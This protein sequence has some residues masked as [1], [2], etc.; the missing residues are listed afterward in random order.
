MQRSIK[1]V[2][3]ALAT[4]CFTMAAGC[5]NAEPVDREEHGLIEFDC[6]NGIRY[7]T[8]EVDF[9]NIYNG[10]AFYAPSLNGY[11]LGY[12]IRYPEG[13][14][15]HPIACGVIRVYRNSQGY[16]TLAVVIEHRLTRP[17][18][19]RNGLNAEVSVDRFISIYGH[20]RPTSLI[21]GAGV[22]TGLHEGDIV[23]PDQII[24]YVEHADERPGH[25][26]EDL[27]GHGDT[28]LHFGIRLQSYADAARI[29]PRSPFR[30]YDVSGD[31]RTYFADPADFMPRLVLA[32]GDIRW[33][34]PGTLL[35]N[36]ENHSERWLVG[37]DEMIHPVDETYLTRERL[38]GREVEVSP[39]EL[40]CYRRGVALPMETW[41]STLIRFD[42]APAV[43]ES[44]LYRLSR[45]RYT[46]I[47]YEAFLSWGWSDAQVE[48]W[49]SS[50]RPAFFA[51]TTDRGFRRMRDG[52]LVKARG[53]PEVSV[54]SD[55]RRL[56]FLNWE[57]FIAMGYDPDDIVE[58][59]PDVIDDVAYPRGAL[60][61]PELAL[62]C[63]TPS[64]SGGDCDGS[65]SEGGGGVDDPDAGMSWSADSGVS[66][67]DSDRDG[68]P[69]R[70][71]CAPSNPSVHA[72]ASELC[73]GL[74]NDCDGIPDNGVP[75]RH[76]ANAC[77]SVIYACLGGYWVP[78]SGRDPS[79]EVCNGGDD[80]CD[81]AVD[82]G[83]C[84]PPP[85]DAGT[86]D[87]GPAAD[88]HLLR[89]RLSDTF[90]AVNPCPDGWEIRLWLDASPEASARGAPLER[91]VSRT[92][93]HSSI[94]L[95]CYTRTPQW[96]DWTG[97]SS[98]GAFAELSLGGVDLRST[99]DI[100][101]DPFAP[102]SGVRPIVMWAPLLRGS[103]P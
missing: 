74:D 67:A 20:Q 8:S 25:E 73:D 38:Y 77:G 69:D 82:E 61:T 43:Y 49:S 33:H 72:G 86:P 89:I 34:P 44:G 32:N 100:C 6:G 45:D 93:G 75:E 29:H 64:C 71:D 1:F 3:L 85:A 68:V 101:L 42:D 84:A 62:L 99:T 63:R 2:L 21:Y 51:R 57:T 17:I 91:T 55:G 97:L 15:I 35:M 81:G 79:P 66:L 83:V 54:V 46:F 18:Q 88:P 36:R 7:P 47:S 95:W 70:D 65:G 23:M 76:E 87:A 98:S 78:T 37:R 60:I 22:G 28:H 13:V 12:D 10:R 39:A 52:T 41:L 31:G 96:N 50:D 94:T 56:P 19:V 5:E 92:D 48:W 58:V 16:G 11:H 40:G 4:L 26:A 90:L 53:S 103:C 102:G 24:S 30:G 80:D 27:N 14:A 59:D 9:R